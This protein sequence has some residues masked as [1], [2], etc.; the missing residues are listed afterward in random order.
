MP[1]LISTE[2]SSLPVESLQAG[3]AL[4]EQKMLTLISD[5]AWLEEGFTAQ[6]YNGSGSAPGNRISFNHTGSG[7]GAYLRTA[8]N[9]GRGIL[10]DPSAPAQAV[11]ISNCDDFRPV[12]VMQWSFEAATDFTPKAGGANWRTEKSASFVVH[13]YAAMLRWRAAAKLRSGSGALHLRLALYDDPA[14]AAQNRLARGD[15]RS[16]TCNAWR[17]F[18]LQL[19]LDGDDALKR[20]RCGAFPKLWYA[21]LLARVDEGCTYYVGDNMGGIVTWPGFAVCT[22]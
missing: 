13:E 12:P 21:A 6:P 22:P 4:S 17:A 10:R 1:T 8:H 14:A 2:Y 11:V 5:A 15:V 3:R 7:S 19:D 20:I 9:P 16:L 18:D